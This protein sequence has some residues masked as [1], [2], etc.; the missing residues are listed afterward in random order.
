MQLKRALCCVSSETVVYPKAAHALY[1]K[2]EIREHPNAFTYYI[3]HIRNDLSRD[4]GR[5]TLVMLFIGSVGLSM[6]ATAETTRERIAQVASPALGRV[7]D[8]PNR[9]RK[10]RPP[11]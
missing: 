7:H 4:H 1:P 9:G 11:S 8:N 2:A 10:P 3:D 5:S 6:L